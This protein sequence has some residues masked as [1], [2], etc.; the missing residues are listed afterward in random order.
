MKSVDVKSIYDKKYFLEAVDGYN[1][2]KEFDGSFD[3]LFDRYKRNVTLLKLKSEHRYLEIGCG[4]GE[5]CIW[6]GLNGGNAK[7]IDFSTDAINLAKLKA[8]KLNSPAV[9]LEAS[10]SELL[11]PNNYYDRIL[12]SEFIEHI[13]K[14]EGQNFFRVAYATLKPGGLLLIYTMPNTLQR[15]YGYPIYRLW[16]ILKGKRLPKKQ[17]DTLSEHYKLY[18]LN[19]QNYFQLRRSAIDAGFSNFII[20]YDNEGTKNK[21]YLKQLILNFIAVT[22]LRHLFLSNLYM[23][24]EK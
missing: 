6:H 23:L 17:D 24:A 22:P 9:F 1:E 21:S 19:E 5:I 12:A 3:S 16:C 4:R 10:F 13:S 2:F 7:G 14:N 18:H 8:E 20:G 15:R 11:E